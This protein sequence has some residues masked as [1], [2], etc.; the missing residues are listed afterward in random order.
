[1]QDFNS[2]SEITATFVVSVFV[3]SFVAG[4]Q[5]YH[6]DRTQLPPW[7]RI[8]P[9]LDRTTQRALRSSV[10][11]SCL[12][13]G[14]SCLHDCL[15][16]LDEHEHAHR[17]P[18]LCWMLG[19]FIIGAEYEPSSYAWQPLINSLTLRCRAL[20]QSRSEGKSTSWCPSIQHINR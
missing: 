13:F 7:L 4:Y 15:R 19:M 2:T 6:A 1:M 8:W 11:L 17:V 3:P 18:V 9:D 12:Q 16:T 14:L 10:H 5:R 20:L